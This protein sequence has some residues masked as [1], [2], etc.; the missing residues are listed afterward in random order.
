MSRLV[1]AAGTLALHAALLAVALVSCSEASQAKPPPKASQGGAEEV[2]VRLLPS[3]EGDGPPCDSY[4]GIGIRSEFTPLDEEGFIR[5]VIEI[6][7]GGPADRAGI[8]LGD[9]ILNDHELGADRHPVGHRIVLQVLRDGIQ[10]RIPVVTSHI[11]Q[12]E[13]REP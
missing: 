12:Q 2:E 10:L 13:R 7:P 8:R 3:V 9:Q 1:A 6:S 5:S 4:R 11:C